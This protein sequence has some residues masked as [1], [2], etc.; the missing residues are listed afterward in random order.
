MCSWLYFVRN[1]CLLVCDLW[2][3]IEKGPLASLATCWELPIP[4]GG[5]TKSKITNH[6]LSLLQIDTAVEKAMDVYREAAE[7]LGSAIEAAQ[8][9]GG[10]DFT[11]WDVIRV[12]PL[13]I[14]TAYIE[15]LTSE[16]PAALI[17]LAHYCLLLTMTESRWYL[18]NLAETLFSSVSVRLG[19]EW[20][21]RILQSFN[22]VQ[23][24][25]SLP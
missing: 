6:L 15:L 14:S 5:S 9:L 19:P 22:E 7:Q 23:G 4:V 10:R 21:R 17:I 3:D 12:W 24:F 2:E 18:G 25:L 20:R 8:A 13:Q 11:T 16:H 1:G